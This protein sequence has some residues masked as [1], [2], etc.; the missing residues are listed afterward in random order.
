VYIRIKLD[1]HNTACVRGHFRSGSR[2][3]GAGFSI[4]AHGLAE[5]IVQGHQGVTKPEHQ[6]G[7]KRQRGGC[8]DV[9]I[10]AH[11]S[12]ICENVT[13]VYGQ[14]KQSQ[15]HGKPDIPGRQALIP[16]FFM[17]IRH[18]PRPA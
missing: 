3:D 18:A 15:H 16:S 11:G 10:A 4:Q 2:A 6:Q 14:R 8:V 9:F 1:G 12:D 13:R 17:P 5:D 7:D